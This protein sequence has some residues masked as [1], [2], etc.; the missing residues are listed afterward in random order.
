MFGS[1]SQRRYDDCVATYRDIMIPSRISVSSLDGTYRHSF[2]PS[3]QSKR[4]RVVIKSATCRCRSPQVKSLS[5]VSVFLSSF[6]VLVNL[7]LPAVTPTTCAQV[8]FD[9]CDHRRHKA[10]ATNA[11]MGCILTEF[12]L[13]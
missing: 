5:N 12:V 13:T 8:N 1:Q 10:D 2:S 9:S 7:K 11:S 6:L 4:R 3:G